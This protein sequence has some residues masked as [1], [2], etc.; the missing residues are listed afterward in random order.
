MSS[1]APPGGL[2]STLPIT[3]APPG[4][5]R[6][7]AA[8]LTAVAVVLIAL[9]LRLG[10][11]SASALLEALRTDLAL[12]PAVAA[13]L[14]ALPTLCFAAAGAGTGALARRAGAERA[15]LLA[16]AALTAG[17]AIRAVPA[18]WALLA[19]TA[20]GMSGLA[21]CNVLLPTLVRTHF[22]GRTGLLTGV[23]TTTLALGAAAASAVSVPL[24]RALGS[25]SLGLAVWAGPALAALM[26][27][28][29]VRARAPRGVK[30]AAG[31]PGERISLRAVARTRAGVLVTAYFGLQAL[32]AYA[33][34]GWLPS[35]LS[36]QGMSEGAA[37]AVLAVTQ[38]VGIPVSFAVLAVAK[39]PG[40]LRG[41]FVGVSLAML[42][43]FTGL[44]VAPVALPMVWAVL[45]GLGMCSFPLVLAVIAQSGG[46][47]A[48]T[49]ALS[50]LAQSLGYLLAAL[51]PLAVGLLHG[52]TGGWTAPMAALLVTAAAQLVAGVLLSRRP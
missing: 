27:W 11:S 44:L 45:V 48:E 30:T 50:T 24:A 39:G 49:T 13:L 23:Y 16:L 18:V 5:R 32:N 1:S 20:L 46:S 28:A 7:R 25:P 40:R 33:V 21:L 42:A 17:L 35:L 19:G 14:P 52:A 31:V 43:G 37:G 36:G 26:M 47:P 3:A 2:T 12:P 34:V 29:A 8:W 9:N 4:P 38:A 10:I 51:G 41:A 15:V 6:A 22:P